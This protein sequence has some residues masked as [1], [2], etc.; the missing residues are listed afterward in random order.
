MMDNVWVRALA[1]VIYTISYQS[2]LTQVFCLPE[3][4]L[5]PA[6]TPK[7]LGLKAYT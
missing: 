6:F 7:S 3:T 5:R 1:L 2:I 4:I